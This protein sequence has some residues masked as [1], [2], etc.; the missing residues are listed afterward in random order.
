MQRRQFLKAGT[1]TAASIGATSSYAKSSEP[2][3][4]VVPFGPGGQSDVLLRSIGER[5]ARYLGRPVIADN[6]A[7]AGGL[8]ALNIIHGAKPDR[9]IITQMSVGAYRMP[10]MQDTPW[11]PVAD[12]TY[13]IRLWGFPIGVAVPTAS[14]FHSMADV[15][16]F[17][18]KEPGAFT[19]GTAGIAVTGHL[20]LEELAMMA[21]VK[22]TH[23][24]FRGGAEAVQATLGNHVLAISDSASWG[25]LVDSGQLRLIGTFTEQRTRWGAP[26]MKEQGYDLVFP[27]PAGLVGPRGMPLPVVKELHDAFKK[28]L[29]EPE[30]RELLKRN[31][32]LVAYQSSEEYAEYGRQAFIAERK[33]LVRLGLSK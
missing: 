17:A 33:I 7:G 14:P 24:P 5:A 16:S 1:A 11:N 26:T 23:V 12:F 8:V 9:N 22:I 15:V 29:D 4:L 2:L 6:K 28:A 3:T 19:F 13:I 32:Q 27:S 30:I 21:G 10:Y 31:D 20:A 25:P 18:R